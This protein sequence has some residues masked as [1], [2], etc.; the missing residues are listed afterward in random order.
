MVLNSGNY[1]DSS[2]VQVGDFHNAKQ[3]ASHYT[4][5]CSF[6]SKLQRQGPYL[7]ETKQHFAAYLWCFININTLTFKLIRLGTDRAV[8]EAI[9]NSLTRKIGRGMWHN[10]QQLHERR[11][12]CSHLTGRSV[13]ASMNCRDTTLPSA[14]TGHSDSEFSCL[15]IIVFWN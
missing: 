14:G 2:P 4:T 15:E 8:Y 11:V 6:G 10:F 1:L 13:C 5:L 7:R 9:F 12:C 3:G